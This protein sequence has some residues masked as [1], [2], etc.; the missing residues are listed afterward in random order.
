M[1]SSKEF[2]FP[3]LTI[4]DQNWFCKIALTNVIRDFNRAE[5]LLWMLH[6]V[7]IRCW[8]NLEIASMIS[9]PFDIIVTLDA[10]EIWPASS[11]FSD[12]DIRS[13]LN[14]SRIVI[15]R[16]ELQ[17]TRGGVLIEYCYDLLL[18][19]FYSPVNF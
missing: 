11:H 9:I 13:N 17:F 8:L 2:N 4:C 3:C 1:M 10:L 6:F 18:G 19:Q 12:N 14:L 16:L 5:I 7:A 15:K